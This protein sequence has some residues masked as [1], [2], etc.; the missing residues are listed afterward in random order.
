MAFHAVSVTGFEGP[1]DLLLELIEA[2]TLDITQVS[3]AQV[4]DQYLQR[5]RMLDPLSPEDLAQFLVIAARL[6]LLKS[7]RLLPELQLTAEE[8]ESI[9]SLEDQL[10]EYQAFRAQ[11]RTFRPRWTSALQL[12]ARESYRSVTA[13]FYPPTGF[14]VMALQG[15]ITTLV[16]GLPTF[17]SDRAEALARVVSLEQRIR[18]LQERVRGA[19]AL[20]F[21]ETVAK[22]SSRADVVV[23]FLALLELVKQRIL[24]A[25]QEGVFHDILVHRREPHG[26]D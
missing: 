16:R 9:L 12:H 2:E 26:L 15:A 24:V 23:S 18:E 17:E 1:L 7:K 14:V 10:R 6:I 5:I 19:A 13:T 25:R 21:R 3:L 11:A 22:G 8:E 20:S 4:T